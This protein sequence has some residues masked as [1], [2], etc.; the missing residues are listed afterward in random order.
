MTGHLRGEICMNIGSVLNRLSPVQG[1]YKI[2]SLIGKYKA[3]C[4]LDDTVELCLI[5]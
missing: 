1:K 4:V 5:S 3:K 2:Y